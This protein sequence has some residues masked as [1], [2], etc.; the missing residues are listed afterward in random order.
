MNDHELIEGL[1]QNKQEAFR[2]LLERYQELVVS[3]CYSFLNN[4]DDAHDIAQDV[5]IEVYKSVHRFRQDA[6]ISTWLY[7]IAANKSL[8]HLRKHKNRKFFL[9][10][11]KLFGAEVQSNNLS[12]PDFTRP[13]EKEAEYSAR[14]EMLHKAIDSLPANQKTAFTLHKFKSLPY[15]DIAEVME[16]SLP[17]IESLIHR[18]KKN[19][20]SQLIKMIEKP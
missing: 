15:K 10:I 1:K 4:S 6:A 7:R 8:N 19:L 16:F 2:L 18:A 14:A 13:L 12:E 17:A 20:Q 5:F 11:E 9:Q 3:T